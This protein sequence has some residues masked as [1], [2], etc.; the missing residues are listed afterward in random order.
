MYSVGDGSLVAAYLPRKLP[1]GSTTTCIPALSIHVRKC[2]WTARIGF[3]KKVRVVNPGSSLSCASNRQRATTSRAADSDFSRIT[4][5]Q[6]TL[7]PFEEV[8]VK[9]RIGLS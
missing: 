5:P 1:A 2:V 7:Q 9:A 8:C 3:D 4:S 6:Y